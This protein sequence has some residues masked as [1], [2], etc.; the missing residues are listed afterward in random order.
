MIQMLVRLFCLIVVFEFPAFAE[1]WMA[2]R[3]SQNCAGCHTPGRKNLIPKDR[4]CSLSCQGCHTNPNGGGL[5]NAYGKWTSQKWLRT[6]TGEFFK[7]SSAPATTAEH[8][9]SKNASGQVNHVVSAANQHPDE[10]L[11]TRDGREFE[12]VSDAQFLKEV[13][14]DDPY[15][16]NQAPVQ[17]GANVRYLHL[18]NEDGPTRQ[19]LMSADVGVAF[20]TSKHTQIVYEGRLLGRF[21]GPPLDEQVDNVTTRSLY[22]IVSD[23]PYNSFAMAGIYKPLFGNDHPDHTRLSRKLVASTLTGNSRATYNIRYRAASVGTAPNV[24]YANIHYIANQIDSTRPLNKT[25]GLVVNT[26]LRFVTLGASV[27]Y[28]YWNQ[29]T[30]EIDNRD[31]R[32]LMHNLYLTS[33]LW[34]NRLH[35]GLEGISAQVERGDLFTK[36]SIYTLESYFKLYR[37]LYLIGEYS[38]ANALPDLSAGDSSQYKFGIKWFLFPGIEI[39]SQMVQEDL[40]PDIGDKTDRQYISTQLHV[41]Y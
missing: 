26:G 12:T 8:E 38:S 37:E 32:V 21:D 30:P 9:A 11:Y 40:N 20:R 6:Y 13:P 16:L 17:A 15:Y 14:K 25:K 28:S 18:D 34:L 39:I 4:R 31:T 1:P 29:T 23:L 7:G 19:F 36:A 3:F 5:R 10:R 24:P 22:G 33:T 41:H 35:L 2:S 27:N